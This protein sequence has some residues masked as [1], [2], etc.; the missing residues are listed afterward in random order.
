MKEQNTY[1]SIQILKLMQ[2]RAKGM[3]A[4]NDSILSNEKSDFLIAAEVFNHW[5]TKMDQSGKIQYI[6]TQI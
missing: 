1:T 2:Y 5:L 6:L 3:D 4:T